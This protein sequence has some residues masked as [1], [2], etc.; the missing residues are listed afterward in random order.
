[1]RVSFER[2][3]TNNQGVSRVEQLTAPEFSTGFFDK[4]RQGLGSR[5]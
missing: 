5:T 4:V 3:V 1:L 2:I